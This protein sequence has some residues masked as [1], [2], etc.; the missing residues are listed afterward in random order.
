MFLNLRSFLLPVILFF[1]AC[2]SYDEEIAQAFAELN[3]SSVNHVSQ[4]YG[5]PISKEKEAGAT[6]YR[7]KY[8][9]SYTYQEPI[10]VYR[11]GKMVVVGYRPVPREAFCTYTARVE[12]GRVQGG[13]TDG[14]AS[15]C[16]RMG[17]WQV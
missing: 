16:L 3:G 5:S 17:R 2:A 15:A 1:G 4:R 14:S 13:S 6:L 10:Q 11:N 7:W 9:Y 12:G 8:S